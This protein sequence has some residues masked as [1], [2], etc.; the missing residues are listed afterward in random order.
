VR[1]GK[2]WDSIESRVEERPSPSAPSVPSGV[3]LIATTLSPLGSRRSG[4][5]PALRLLMMIYSVVVVAGHL[6]WSFLPAIVGW[7]RTLKRRRCL[8][9]S[10][11]SIQRHTDEYLASQVKKVFAG[12]TAGQRDWWMDRLLLIHYST[13]STR[14]R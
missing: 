4:V 5:D 6:S 1:R 13:V 11:P 10:F 7:R 3:P 8:S 14:A 9:L 12:Q 2:Y